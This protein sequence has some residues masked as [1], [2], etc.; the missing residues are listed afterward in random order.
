MLTKENIVK[1]KNF[2]MSKYD[3]IMFNFNLVYLG[4]IFISKLKDDRY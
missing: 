1:K 4:I 2:M 3:L